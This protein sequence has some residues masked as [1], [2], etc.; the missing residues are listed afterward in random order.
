MHIALAA[1][2]ALQY[3]HEHGVIHR[4][5]KPEN[6]LLQAGQPVVADFG[7]AL[8]VT[9][10]GGTRLTQTG[11]SLGTPQYMSPEQ[12][13]GD[14]SIDGRSDI[15]SLAAILY[16]MLTGDPPHTGSTAQ[17]V[18]ARV[19]TEKARGVRASRAN[20]PAHVDAAIACALEKLPA[21]RFASAGEF[22]LA[23]QGSAVAPAPAVSTTSIARLPLA[24]W[25]L[26]GAVFAAGL[27]VGAVVM[28]SRS[29]ANGSA[30]R[31]DA[32]L[33]RA[34]IALPATA[35]LALA[36][37]PPVG[38][39]GTELALAPDGSMLAYVAATAAGNML[40]VHDVATGETRAMP[41]TE[42][43]KVAVFSPDGAWIAFSTADHLKKIPRAG[44]GAIELCEGSSIAAWWP[45]P[46]YIYFNLGG[47]LSRVSSEGGKPERLGT[48]RMFGASSFTD[49]L[50][51]GR[52]MLI[53]GGNASMNAEHGDVLLVDIRSHRSTMLI[54][55]AFAARYVPG[56]HLI[57]A[58]AG[59]LFAVRFDVNRLAVEGNP[60]AIA[61]GV[62]METAFGMLQ[63]S[64]AG[65]VL[66][67]VP[68]V[69]ASRGKLAWVDRPGAV[70]FIDAPEMVYGQI[71]LSPDDQRIAIHIADVQD[72]LWIWNLA[73]HEGQRVTS[74]EAEGLPRWSSD[75]RRL[76]GVQM[77]R[78]RIMI[79]DVS[80]AGQVG[81]GTVAPDSGYAATLS[82]SGDVLAAAI[83][84]GP[85]RT[86]FIALQPGGQVPPPF[87]GTLPTFSPD[88][89]WVAYT[90]E[91]RGHPEVFVRS[92]AEG[93]EIG[94]VSHGGGIEPRWK[95][96]GVLYFRNGHRW[97]ETKVATNPE[98]R[99]DPPRQIFDVDFIDTQGVSYDVTRDGQRLLVVK[100][101]HPMQTSRIELIT[102]WTRLL[103]PKP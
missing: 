82:P 55:S 96:S 13:T 25:A 8:A 57:F 92:Y 85:F 54:R 2:R 20:V 39:N 11:I 102:N 41:G 4:D 45:D 47:V 30:A 62:A 32:P 5:V 37:L 16:E 101:D 84:A 7:I 86:G 51:G 83:G 19:V 48:A 64:A 27:I 29:G 18:I 53:N 89:K 3:A 58:R 97:Y 23:L 65:G 67:Y 78:P 63:A 95:P 52:T 103:E 88:G 44:G 91:E 9:N 75:G 94:Q 79:H 50:P 60:V 31:T 87:L 34:S 71:D 99:W 6:I 1:A 80:A 66:A 46:E 100:S 35:P 10:A 56:G 43:V 61:S 14:R 68:G 28:R 73:R 98:P 77:G 33:V 72:Y 22:A 17:A 12:A 81:T 24:R 59:S 36:N 90:R 38:F 70:D 40:Y 76:V 49:V 69:D 26:G 74:T 42:G 21:D 93:R 15:Y